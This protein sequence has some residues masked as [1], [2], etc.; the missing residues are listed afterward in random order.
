REQRAGAEVWDSALVLAGD[1]GREVDL[2]RAAVLNRELRRDAPGVLGVGEEA[3]LPSRRVGGIADVAREGL[4]LA[5][6]ERGQRESAA[7]LRDTVFYAGLPRSR[8]RVEGQL[9]RAGRIARHA[10]I[11]RL[12]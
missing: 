6:Q 4:P 5:Q 3:F 8:D 2:V 11:M 12:S 7:D 1:G 9:P 10:Q